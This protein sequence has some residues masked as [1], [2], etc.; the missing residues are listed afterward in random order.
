MPT[1]PSNIYYASSG[2]GTALLFVHGSGADHKI[3]G[4]QLK[5]L[6]KDFN[7][8]AIDLNGHDKSP[9]REGP[10]LETYTKDTLDVIESIDQPVVLLGHSLGGALALNVALQ[11]PE[12]IE[13]LG[14]IG[15]GAR[16]KV[17]PELLELIET[18][19]EKA[20]KMVIE[21]EFSKSPPQELFDLALAQIIKNGQR[22]LS[23]DL[24]TCNEFDV[25]SQLESITLPTLVLCG[26]EDKLTP[27]KYSEF[28]QNGIQNSRLE[29][30]EDAGHN[31]ML[32]QPNRLN[33]AIRNF[34][35]GLE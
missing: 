35:N 27:V 6:S 3:W 15:T 23:R 2:H 24:N 25:I 22:T 21:W 14:L 26:K 19:F 8:N 34:V 4:N 1:T 10:G 20:A 31:V 16:L 11:H 5:E 18:D 32:E 9:Y 30:I 28:L 29:I 13:A 17:L 33:S 12:K 7:V